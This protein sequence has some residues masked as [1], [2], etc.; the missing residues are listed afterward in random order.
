[1]IRPG[2]APKAPVLAIGSDYG[3]FDDVSGYGEF[4]AAPPPSGH[5]SRE[6]IMRT[7]M[8]IRDPHVLSP[9]YLPTAGIAMTK[10]NPHSAVSGS[11]YGEFSSASGYGEF[12]PPPPDGKITAG[13][14]DG[15]FPVQGAIGAAKPFHMVYPR[16]PAIE[17]THHPSITIERRDLRG[18]VNAMTPPAIT[19]PARSNIR[20]ISFDLCIHDE[21]IRVLYIRA[22]KNIGGVDAI[23]KIMGKIVQHLLKRRGNRTALSQRVKSAFA[24]ASDLG[25]MRGFHDKACSTT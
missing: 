22:I 10:S 24:L 6:N 21:R 2:S 11:N 1:M 4:Q 13:R 12:A 7:R 3:A 17:K 9:S 14:T 19:T 8:S 16:E 23:P 18:K 15:T 25:R 20:P 5:Q